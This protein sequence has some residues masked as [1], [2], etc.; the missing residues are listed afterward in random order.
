MKIAVFWFKIDLSFFLRVQLS[1]NSLIQVMAWLQTGNK[2]LP[3]PIVT[4]FT[5]AC[6]DHQDTMS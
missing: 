5:D 4:H 1:I 6:M 2:P 3:E